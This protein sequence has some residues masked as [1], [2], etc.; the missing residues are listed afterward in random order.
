MNK[1][2][3]KKPDFLWISGNPVLDF[4]NTR[5]VL[6]GQTVELLSDFPEVLRWFVTAN[7]LDQPSASKLHKQ[8]A[9]TAE[10]SA[11]MR[12]L[13]LFREQLRHAIESLESRKPVP[14]KMIAELNRLLAQH[15][16]VT[17]VAAF[18]GALKRQHYLQPRK[19]ADLFAPLAA[20]AAGLFTSSDPRPLRQCESCVLHFRD[21][22]KNTTRRWCSMKLCGNRAKVAAYAARQQPVVA[23]GF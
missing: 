12:Q 1:M 11:F 9:N 14:P 3:A 8:W 4:V 7:L 23:A 15:P 13:L 10:A 6:R 18:N 2:A 16:L 5:P 17:Q 19:P 22:T 20:A 21:T